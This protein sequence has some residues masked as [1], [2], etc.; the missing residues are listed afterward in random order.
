[1][2]E[3]IAINTSC[4]WCFRWTRKRGERAVAR[5]KTRN[6]DSLR[7]MFVL[8]ICALWKRYALHFFKT[9]VDYLK[10]ESVPRARLTA[11]V[12]V[13]VIFVC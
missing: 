2:I 9:A 6:D 1:M 5:V 12:Q 8:A 4:H 7:Q 3:P 10:I 13:P 11:W